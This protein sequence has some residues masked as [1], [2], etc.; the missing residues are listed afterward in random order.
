MVGWHHRLNA[1]GF[2][3]TL[4]IGEGQ[5]GLACCDS[6]GHKELDTTEWLNWTEVKSY[7]LL[8][9]HLVYLTIIVD[10]TRW[11]GFSPLWANLIEFIYIWILIDIISIQYISVELYL[12]KLETVYIW[13]C[14]FNILDLK[15][16]ETNSI[17]YHKCITRSKKSIRW[18]KQ[19]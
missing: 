14:A 10:M 16:Q 18:W 15:F 2:G 3:R 5:G 1:H 8:L 13:L 12:W 7:Y 4:G 11:K 17:R 19:R 6:W 9:L